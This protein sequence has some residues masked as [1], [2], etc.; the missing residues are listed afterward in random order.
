[1]PWPIEQ[2]RAQVA[3]SERMFESLR[4]LAE[5]PRLGQQVIFIVGMPRSGTTL[6]EQILAS[7]IQVKGAGE[8]DTLARVL[9][10]ES[11]R[12]QKRYPEWTQ[13]ATGQDWQR[14]GQCYLSLTA[15]WCAQRPRFVDKMPSNWRLLGAVRA[16]LP[17]ARIII[18]RR[19]RL[20]NCWS[21]FKQYFQN[22]A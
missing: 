5:D 13:E 10:E 17:G 2:F 6:V 3:E 4:V 12:R 1:R 18:C 8:L 14:L 20:E 19:D 9:S 11:K 16:M 15:E 21:C 7:H 22:G